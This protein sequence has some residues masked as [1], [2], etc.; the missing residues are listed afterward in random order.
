MPNWRE[1]LSTSFFGE[2][3]EQPTPR[4]PGGGWFGDV[5]LSLQASVRAGGR[6]EYRYE[7]LGFRC[8]RTEN[9]MSAAGGSG[10]AF[11]GGCWG[12]GVAR[13]LRSSNRSRGRPEYRDGLLGFRCV[14]EATG[15]PRKRAKLARDIVDEVLRRMK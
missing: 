2:R 10:R 8:V 7:N 11:R 5:A 4:L 9:E 15:G 14:R 6:P 13:Y 3:N 1:T 12:V